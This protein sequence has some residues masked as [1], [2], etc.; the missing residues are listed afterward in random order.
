MDYNFD[1][2]IE[3][4]STNSIKWVKY[5]EDV[6]P[7]WVADMD[8]ATPQPIL[9]ALHRKLEQKILG[10]EMEY[11]GLQSAVCARMAKLYGW[12]LS[13][14]MVV[15]TPGVVA[16]FN[17][18]ARAFC[19]PGESY[20]IQPPVYFPFLEIS[21]NAGI[22]RID[23][24][25]VKEA[26]GNNLHYHVGHEDFEKAV[27][28]S[29]GKLRMF[30]LCN[31][32]NPTGQIFSSSDLRRMAEVCMQHDVVMVSDEIHS[33]LI[34][35]DASFKP[36]ATFSPEI[37][38]RTVTLVAPS[39]TFNV[40]GLFCGMAIIPDPDLRERFKKS[41]EK[42]TMHVSSL[43]LTAAEAALSGACDDWLE[44]LRAYVTSNRDLVV[45]F[46]S[47]RLP[48]V[49]TTIPDATYMAWFDCTELIADGKITGSPFE[50]FLKNAKV[51]LNDGGPF[52]GGCEKFVRFNFGSPRSLVIEAL[53]RIEKSIK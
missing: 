14:E 11:A 49:R 22:G 15:V 48:G 17:A 31:P 2:V 44:A 25:L 1:A 27:R 45:D 40:A 24:P 38:A 39:K 7:M 51:A 52:G 36:I 42:L 10:Y 53:E 5:D 6:L 33:E 3:R 43:G 35:G 16:A 4:R 50:F 20:L 19:E 37:A 23:A 8:F 9:D 34:L 47:E 13:P 26:D 32:H 29:N 30:L 46:V 28:S 12:E 21:G 41:A 18:A